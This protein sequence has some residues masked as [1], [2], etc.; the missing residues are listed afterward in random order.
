MAVLTSFGL[1]Y[2][3]GALLDNSTWVWWASMLPAGYVVGSMIIL[4][5]DDRTPFSCGAHD[6]AASVAV[7]LE[8]GARL[9]ARP[10]ENTQVWLAFTGAEETDHAGLHALLRE[11]DSVMR[12]AVFIGM[13]GVGSGEIVYLTEQ[14]VCAHY[15][16]DPGLLSIASEVATRYD[17]HGAQMTMEDEVGTLRR[18]GYR[19]ICI[20][21]LDPVT[22]S[23]P[24]WHR[25]DDTADSVS[26]KVMEK[27]ADYVM[28]L[29]KV[30]DGNGLVAQ[31]ES[32]IRS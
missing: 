16:P 13:E 32:C 11:H 19:A 30:L 5:R 27:S 26:G 23:L 18:C 14:G 9:K 10:L 15:R 29:L 3:T 4:W 17:V 1:L 28:A 31:E 20:A 22:G 12:Q 25:A 24:R 6:N 2:L 21:G 8:I 7:A